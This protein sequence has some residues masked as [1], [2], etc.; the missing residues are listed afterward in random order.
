[1]AKKLR[2]IQFALNFCHVKK[3]LTLNLLMLLAAI[4]G[5]FAGFY[6]GV[7]AD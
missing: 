1:M 6:G 4:G 2:L 3:L 7:R 5:G